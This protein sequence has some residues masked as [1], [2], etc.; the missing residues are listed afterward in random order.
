MAIDLDD[1]SLDDLKALHAR[2]AKAI[3]GFVDRKKAAALRELDSKAREFG[4]TLA[5]LTGSAPVSRKRA[6]AGAKYANPANS[7]DTWSGRG[8]K[9]RW[10]VEAL[11]A[12]KSP[13]D[14][15]I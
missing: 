2:V 15:L 12:G 10:F 8:R 1:M 4:F 7:A 11:A 5:E 6:P 14:L 9:P 13:D 3:A